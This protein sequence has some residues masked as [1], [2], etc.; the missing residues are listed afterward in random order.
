VEDLYP[1]IR[2]ASQ[3]RFPHG[4]PYDD[5][6]GQ[7]IKDSEDFWGRIAEDCHW[8]KKWDKVLDNSRKSFSW[9]FTG[10]ELNTCYKALDL[11]VDKDR[12]VRAGG[13]LQSGHGGQAAA[14]DRSNKD[15]RCMIQKIADNK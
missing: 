11:H 8:T 7:S 15:L 14:P 12:G 5:A 1:L 9:W 3:R 2:L 10:W 13:L 6:H 4:Q